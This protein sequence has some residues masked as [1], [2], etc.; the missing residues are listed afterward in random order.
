MRRRDLLA[1]LGSSA[2][3]SPF[4]VRAQ[5]KAMPVIGFLHF[6]SPGPSAPFVAGFR[7]GLNDSGFVE[8]QNV[9]IEYRWAEGHYDRLPA[10]AAELVGR[11]VAL[12]ATLSGTPTTLAAKAATSAIPIVFFTGADPVVEGVVASFARPGGSLT[13]VAVQVSE[14]TAKRLQLLS[15]L[16]PDAKVIAFLVNPTYAG[17]E[18]SIRNLQ[19]AARTKAVQ[20]AIVKATT[21]GEIDAA[22]ASLAKLHAGALVIGGD[23]FFT[24]QREQLAALGLRDGVPAIYTTRLFA[25]VGG[26]ISYG[27]SFAAASRQAGALAGRI[28]NGANPAD[29]PVEQPTKFELVINLKTAKALGLAVPQSLLAR[30]DEVIE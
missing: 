14:L 16:V 15:E 21:A 4:A 5:Q 30:A 27:P 18:R 1:L 24:N 29:L 13:G 2:A 9:V 3:L 12:I 17:A 11:G 20:L 28:L 25:V 6:A 23:P 19:E 26:L 22:F 10:L 7:Q 8:G